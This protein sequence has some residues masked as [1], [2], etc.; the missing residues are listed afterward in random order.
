MYLTI[1]LVAIV[2]ALLVSTAGR[3]SSDRP[4]RPSRAPRRNAYRR[5]RWEGWL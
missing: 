3:R 5:D 2:A 1:T 4:P